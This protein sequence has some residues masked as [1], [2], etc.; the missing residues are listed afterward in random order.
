M[1]QNKNDLLVFQ[2]EHFRMKAGD[3]QVFSVQYQYGF[4]AECLSDLTVGQ[5]R[6]VLGL[7]WYSGAFDFRINKARDTDDGHDT[8]FLW[9]TPGLNQTIKRRRA[10]SRVLVL[11][12][13]GC[14]VW[15]FFSLIFSYF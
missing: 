6:D 10:L 3:Q 11:A 15:F 12:W 9:L 13:L 5:L 7:R 1:A 14:T 4:C 2:H 8:Y